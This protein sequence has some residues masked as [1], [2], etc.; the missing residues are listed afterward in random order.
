MLLFTKPTTA[1]IRDFLAGQQRLD[2]SYAAVGATR[3]TPPLGFVVDPTRAKLGSGAATFTAAKA[4]LRR[5]EQFHLGWVE[6]TDPDTPLE[7]GR[8]V[9][10]LARVFGVWSLNACR[11]VYTVDEE[12]RF[13]HAYGTLP[14]HAERGEERFL[15]EY[16]P[17]DDAVWFDILA[18][19]RP[20]GLLMKLGYPFVRRKQR[21]F[22]R[23]AVAA[24]RRAVASPP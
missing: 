16:D 23:D 7:P 14:A 24:M 8:C 18:F 6:I 15:V 21:Q 1:A 9:A 20:N 10:V 13:G 17:A 11:I 22:A 5:W 2:F 19:S 12:H 4:A 3:T